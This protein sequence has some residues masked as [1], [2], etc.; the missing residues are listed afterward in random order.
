MCLLSLQDLALFPV[1]TVLSSC[2]CLYVL[3]QNLDVAL[4]V[5]G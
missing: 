5:W 1:Y 3:E 4:N 2:L